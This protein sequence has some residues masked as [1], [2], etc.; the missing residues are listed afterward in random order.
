MKAVLEFDRPEDDEQIRHA[1]AGAQYYATI[2]AFDE[3]L[4]KMHARTEWKD[5]TIKGIL[6][7]WQEMTERLRI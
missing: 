3:Y 1:L 5:E 4:E 6:T 7:A 2:I